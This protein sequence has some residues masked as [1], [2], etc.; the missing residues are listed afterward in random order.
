MTNGTLKNQANDE[1]LITVEGVLIHRSRVYYIN[2]LNRF[3]E[4]RSDNGKFLTSLPRFPGL[5]FIWS[6]GDWISNNDFLLFVPHPQMLSLPA[7]CISDDFFR[8]YEM[9]AVNENVFH[10][11]LRYVSI[12]QSELLIITKLGAQFTKSQVWKDFDMEWNSLEQGSAFGPPGSRKS[13]PT[14]LSPRISIQIELA[15]FIKNT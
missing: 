15:F 8:V 12:F 7:V 6:P 11:T 2:R 13:I 9:I 5:S 14:G 1:N 4:I 3:H 10:D